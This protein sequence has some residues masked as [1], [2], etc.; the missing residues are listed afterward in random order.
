MYKK[1]KALELKENFFD[2]IGNNWMLVCANDGDKMNAMT[3]SWGCPGVVWNEDVFTVFIRDQRYTRE[4][5]D[6]EDKFTISVLD[7]KEYREELKYLGRESGR[8]LDKIEECN[9]SYEK[10]NGYPHIKEAYLHIDCEVIY[11]DKFEE[12]KF[13]DKSIVQKNYSKKDF[14]NVYI[15]RIKNIYYKE[16]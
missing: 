11:K 2:L 12:D 10:V 1:I 7:S 8:N 3:A 14:S 5:I 15:G 6:K 13:Y 16:K 9:L 4:L